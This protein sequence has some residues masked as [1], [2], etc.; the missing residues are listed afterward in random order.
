MAVEPTDHNP[1]ASAAFT[2]ERAMHNDKTITIRLPRDLVREVHQ[3]RL[4]TAARTGIEL[5][6]SEAIRMLLKRALESGGNDAV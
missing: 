5:S 3:Y 4:K 1:A 2:M 6:R